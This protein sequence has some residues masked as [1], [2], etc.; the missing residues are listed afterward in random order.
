[1]RGH[2]DWRGVPILA[3]KAKGQQ[4]QRGG[5]CTK[6]LGQ[7]GSR[8]PPVCDLRSLSPC[9][10]SDCPE[11]RGAEIAWHERVPPLATFER[12]GSGWWDVS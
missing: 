8:V 12:A 10:L 3:T 6:A 5:I 4:N 2:G 9:F 7:L 11:C 1:M